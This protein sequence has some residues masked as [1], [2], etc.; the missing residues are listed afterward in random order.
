MV[1]IEFFLGFEGGDGGEL[2]VEGGD[3][4]VVLLGDVSVEVGEGMDG[5]VGGDDHIWPCQQVLQDVGLIDLLQDFIVMLDLIYFAQL[6]LALA[7]PFLSVPCGLIFCQF[8]LTMLLP[9][10]FLRFLLEIDYHLAID[11]LASTVVGGGRRQ[12]V[13]WQFAGI[14][15]ELV[16]EVEVKLGEWSAGSATTFHED[17]LCGL[18]GI[19]GAGFGMEG[20]EVVGIL[21]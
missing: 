20:E 2:D 4:L 17:F 8:S 11:D 1:L 14:T 12:G 21:F 6:K 15:G 7:L 18:E 13:I 10:L 9:L 19:F 16:L 5:A 3:G